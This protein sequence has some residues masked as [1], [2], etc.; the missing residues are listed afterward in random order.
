MQ[1]LPSAPLLGPDDPPPF[2]VHNTSGKAPLLLLCDH[3]SKAVPKSLNMLGITD[4]ELS[5]HVGWD[6]GG[7][8]SALKY[9]GSHAGVWKATGEEIVQ[10]YLASG[11][12]FQSGTRGRPRA[13]EDA[14]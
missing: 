5:Q 12:T 14:W 10:A 2:T 13:E 1:P 3:A 8:D 11:T 9:I 7:L 6:I 4:A